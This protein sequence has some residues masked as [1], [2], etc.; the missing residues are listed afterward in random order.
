M[1]EQEHQHA[2]D[3]AEPEL[4]YHYTDQKGLLGIIHG[5]CIWATHIRYLNDTSEG[6]IFTKLLQSELSQRA[7]TG[8]DEPLSQ[9]TALAQLMGLSVGQAG[10]NIQCA[11][12]EVLDLGSSA[13]SWISC[14]DSFVASFS[15]QGNLLSQ[16]RAYSGDTSGYCI[17]F[18]R[19]YLKSVGVHF[20]ESRKDSFYDDSN[21]LVA[22]QYCDKPEEESLKREIE[23]IVDSYITETDQVQWQT[24]PEK[25]GL[26]ALGAIAKK[27]FFPLGKRRAITKDQ[28]F[29]EEAEWRLVFQLEKAG[30]IN[31][32]LEFRPGRSM[33]IPYFKVDLTWENQP[34]EV[35]EIIVGPCPHPLDAVNSVQR[36]LRKEGIPKSEVRDSKIPYRNW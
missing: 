16:W 10:S 9:L 18:T 5:K 35:R 4:L 21:P 29:R 11:N 1:E 36:L 2:E 27:H 3:Q 24:T 32:K 6:Q 22:C 15:E 23:Q 26:R 17:G 8:P 25:E 31:S 34:L 12:K 33:P 30:T 28:A 20:L 19:P 7:T 14:Q 13:F